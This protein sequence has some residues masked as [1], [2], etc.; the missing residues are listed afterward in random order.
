M[1]KSLISRN[2]KGFTL[3]EI[4]AVL[5]ILG[6]LAAVAVPRYFSMVDKAQQSAIQGAVAA[7]QSTAT[8]EYASQLIV[9]PGSTYAPATT[10]GLTVGDFTGNIAN[11]GGVV[12]VSV[13]AVPSGYAA[14]N[15]AGTYGSKSFRLY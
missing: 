3:I 7:L 6:M 4:I 13:T 5:V 8:S 9:G 10:S 14:S 12:T 15:W 2:E 11:A 1:E